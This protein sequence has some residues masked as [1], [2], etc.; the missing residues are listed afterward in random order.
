MPISSSSSS[1][2]GSRSVTVATRTAARCGV[3][4]DHHRARRAILAPT[5]IYHACA[6]IAF[7]HTCSAAQHA[8]YGYARRKVGAARCVM[9][10]ASRCC[11]R[12]PRVA[13]RHT[14]CFERACFIRARRLLM[15]EHCFEMR[16]IAFYALLLFYYI[17]LRRL[18]A[19]FRHHSVCRTLRRAL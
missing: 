7:I 17:C 3:D 8:R 4:R 1:S 14:R 9:R 11:A 5:F 19:R 16:S 15:F 10:A 13:L 12:P 6:C 18:R 2:G